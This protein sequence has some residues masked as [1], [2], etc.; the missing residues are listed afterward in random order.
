MFQT[1]TVV[2]GAATSKVAGN[3]RSSWIFKALSRRCT[4]TLAACSF[5]VLLTCV[6]GFRCCDYDYGLN[7]SSRCNLS[8]MV[9]DECDTKSHQAETYDSHGEVTSF[10][11]V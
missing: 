1:M 10:V 4:M 6:P 3:N 7:T 9:P 8:S 2:T 11:S 5:F